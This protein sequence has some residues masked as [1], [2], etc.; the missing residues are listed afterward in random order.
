MATLAD[1]HTAL[2]KRLATIPGLQTRSHP[3][4]GVKPPVAFVQMSS[5]ETETMGRKGAVKRYDFSVIVGTSQGVRPQDGYAALVEFADFA[6]DRS[7][8]LA[9]RD[10]NS[11]A[12]GTFAGLADTSAFVRSFNVLGSAQ[13]DAYEMYGGEFT[14]EVHT[15]GDS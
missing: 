13:M 2:E 10:G 6:G 4:Q 11:F 9:I 1:I 5:W 8:E 7:I 3:P 12:D 15:K 14:V